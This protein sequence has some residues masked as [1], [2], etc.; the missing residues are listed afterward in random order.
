[1]SRGFSHESSI[2]ESVEWYTPPEI[3]DAIG[4][5]FD[6]DPCSPGEGKDFVPARKRYTVADDGLNSS[7]EGYVFMN[8]PYGKHTPSWMQKLADH[9]NGIALVYSRTDVRWFQDA[10]KTASAVCFILSRVR[11]YKASKDVRGGTPGAGSV[12]IAFGEKARHDVL[13]CGLGF[14]VDLSTKLS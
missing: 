10:I 14:C 9:N 5:T 13:Q 8:P 7:W 11:F 3:F 12:L 6:L 2:N 4:A 1:M